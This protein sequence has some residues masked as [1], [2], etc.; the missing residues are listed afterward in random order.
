MYQSVTYSDVINTV[1]E[2]CSHRSLG[3]EEMALDFLVRYSHQARFASSAGFA[4]PR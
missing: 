3:L 2:L 4:G 1:V